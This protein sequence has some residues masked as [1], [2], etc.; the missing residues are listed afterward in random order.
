[1]RLSPSLGAMSV[2]GN[3]EFPVNKGALCVKGAT[4]AVTLDHPDRL[5]TPLARNSRG[6]LVP[7]DWDHALDR[8]TQAFKQAQTRYGMDAVGIFGGGSLTNEKAYLLGKFARVALGT[9]NIDYN[10]RF[11]MS[12]AAAASAMSLGVD[13]GLPF[14]LEDIPFADVILLAG[15]NVAETMPPIMRFFEAQRARGGRLIVVDPRR[16]ITAQQ[17][18]LHLGLVPGSDAALANGL[19]HILVREGMIDSDYIQ[20]RTEGFAQV[21]GTVATYWPDRVER[22]TGIPESKL[23]QA[24]R[25]LGTARTAM[26][27]TGRG[28]EQ[29]SQG[30]ANTL[31][32][33]NIALALG[34]AG[35]PHSGYGCLTGQGNGQG[36]REHGQKADQLPG[37]RKIDDPAARRH[38]SFVWGI[39]ESELPGPGLSAYEMLSSA[40]AGGGVRALM[41]VGSNVVVSAP[42]SLHVEERIKSLDFLAVADFFL[43]ETAEMADVVFPTTQWAEEEGTMTNLEGRVI[44]RRRARPAPEGAHSD[45]RLLCALAARLGKGRHFNFPGPREVFDEL[46]AASRGGPADYSGITYQKIISNNGVFWPCPSEEHPGSPHLFAERFA[47][48][49]GRARF[50]AV[51]HQPPAEEPENEYPL[52]LTTGRILAH[53]QS[54]NQTRRVAELQELTP[55][56]MAE[57]HP[58]TARR[59]NLAGGEMVTLRSRRGAARFK[60]KVTLGARED[61]IFV[62]F[63]WGAERSINRLTN[64][65]LDPVS[66]MPEF[67]VCAV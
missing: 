45:L 67:K 14:P 40:G 10:G 31:A 64:P 35:R 49:N 61:M 58:A 48:S 1:M 16:S 4:A 11:C 33:I 44:M 34:M 36:G 29:Q 23:V 25:M 6:M 55:E 46:R 63:H 26:V 50:H 20:D 9:S 37:Y 8:T 17:A 19:L 65:A 18:T 21:K 54:G 41:V 22:I 28:P 7:V 2:S 52:Y 66:R 43:S 39:D 13:R 30:V 53:Y 15:G 5:L 60:L 3:E 12:S 42:N 38:I 32:Y 59:Y 24:A 57:I 62:P 47:T 51:R 56:P 27:L